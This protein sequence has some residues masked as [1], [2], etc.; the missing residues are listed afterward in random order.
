MRLGHSSI[1]YF[2]Q[3]KCPSSFTTLLH[4]T[5]ITFTNGTSNKNRTKLCFFY[6]FSLQNIRSVTH[7]WNTR[8]HKVSRC[9]SCTICCKIG[10]LRDTLLLQNSR[11]IFMKFEVLIV[12]REEN[13][14]ILTSSRCSFYFV[15]NLIKGLLW[16]TL[17]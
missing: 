9:S 7:P 3:P 6:L 8:K 10:P 5:R 15:P 12:S 4:R 1:L 2:M 14:P 17:C 11:Q 13:W 16:D